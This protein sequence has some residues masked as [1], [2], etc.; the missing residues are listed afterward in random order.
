MDAPPLKPTEAIPPHPTLS[1]YYKTAADREPFVRALF[2]ETAPWY[3]SISAV[4]SFGSDNWY[5]RDALKRAGYGAGLKLLDVATGTGV[6]ARAAASLARS[7]DVIGLD[8]SLGMLLAGRHRNKTRAVQAFGE[9]LPFRSA[10]FDLLSIGYALRHMSDLREAFAEHLRVLKPGGRVLI[11]EITP[12][13]S[14]LGFAAL[15]TYMNGVVPPLV[16]L[17]TR[18]KDTA[19]LMR[20]YW[21]T[22]AECVPPESILS[23]L[24][25]A[26][27]EQVERQVRFGVMSE[28]R[29]M[30]PLS[31]ARQDPAV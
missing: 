5:R 19:T 1:G 27:F 8:P 25:D 7:E 11:L 6:V 15:R 13:S 12:P 2:D 3:E 30:R 14:K 28:Y 23:A 18:K 10:S 24:R 22:I 16:R 31:A 29:G 20:Y 17:M 21:D 4:L 9:H 26:G